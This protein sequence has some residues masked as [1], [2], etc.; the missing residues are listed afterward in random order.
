MSNKAFL[1]VQNQPEIS[2]VRIQERL[3]I[4]DWFAKFCSHFKSSRSTF[5]HAAA[6]YDRAI[7]LQWDHNTGI[8]LNNRIMRLEVTA[9]VC[10]FLAVK[11]EEPEPP[12][13]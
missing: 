13:L 8:F 2:F 11:L 5:A 6:F 4:I 3:T 10:L 7:E 12:R 9:V 1:K